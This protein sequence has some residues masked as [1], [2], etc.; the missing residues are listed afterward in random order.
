MSRIKQYTS[1]V[2]AILFI[3]ALTVAFTTDTAR[4]VSL[5]YSGSYSLTNVDGDAGI[6]ETLDLNV[7]MLPNYV[8]T[9]DPSLDPLIVQYSY[10]LFTTEFKLDEST[11]GTTYDFADNPYENAFQLYDAGNNLLM[12]ADITMMSLVANATTATSNAQFSMNLTNIDVL[13][14]GSPILDAFAAAPGG[15]NNFTFNLAGEAF[16][17]L[18][19]EG[20]G[21]SFS[22]SAAP[23]PE[24]STMLLMGVGL[25]GL[26]GYSRKRFTKK[27]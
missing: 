11:V 19:A 21:G 1:K 13:V 7:S 22:A 25:L 3:L 18:V 2:A 6:Y 15:G 4:A 14:A 5:D 26:A 10:V 23:V 24:P 17:D 8:T 12:E 16:E 27:S 9:T 20:G